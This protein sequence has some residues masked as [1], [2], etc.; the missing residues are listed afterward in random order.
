MHQQ[1]VDFIE[2]VLDKY[3]NYKSNVNIIDVGSCDINGNNRK[4][5]VEPYQY[6][7]LDVAIGKNVDIVAY[8]HEYETEEKY[9]V[10][11]SGEMLEHDKYY[12]QSIPKMVDLTKSGGIMI[13]T[14][15]STG[16]EEHGTTQAHSWASPHTNDWYHNISTEEFREII[17]L[18]VFSK[19][20]LQYNQETK[21]LYFYAIKK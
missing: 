5:F 15:A 2:S 19:Y 9:D 10:V 6:T 4:F 17:D 21:D 14:C 3:P 13:M 1:Q 20:D 12:K 16:R 7:G 8:V 18:T 11:I